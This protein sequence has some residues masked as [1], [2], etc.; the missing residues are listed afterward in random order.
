MLIEKHPSDWTLV[1]RAAVGAAG[2]GLSDA[3]QQF[4]VALLALQP[5]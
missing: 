5:T 1:A 2:A 3:R 4:A